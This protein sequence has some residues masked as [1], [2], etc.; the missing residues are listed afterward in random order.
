MYYT[1]DMFVK[2]SPNEGP[3]ITTGYIDREIYKENPLTHYDLREYL[4]RND[5]LLS[6]IER[7]LKLRGGKLSSIYFTRIYKLLSDV[8]TAF[9]GKICNGEKLYNNVT[10]QLFGIDIAMNDNYNPMIMEVN[11]GPDMEAKDERDSN[12]KHKVVQDI[13]QI[14]NIAEGDNDFI[15]VLDYKDG[16]IVTAL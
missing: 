8:F 10:F 5:R 15:Q 16:E 2:N 13:M 6:P 3:N 14:I 7:H 4:D 1:K 12:L 9:I 11:K